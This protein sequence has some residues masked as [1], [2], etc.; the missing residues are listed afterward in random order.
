MWYVGESES[1]WRRAGCPLH[2][3]NITVVP[4]T[5]EF[6][7]NNKDQV[8]HLFVFTQ[9]LV[10]LII[11]IIIIIIIKNECHSSIIVDRLQGCGR[12]NYN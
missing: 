4:S 8:L 9:G 7:Q 10:L 1:D 5:A 3:D 2:I 6:Y 11:I 12:I